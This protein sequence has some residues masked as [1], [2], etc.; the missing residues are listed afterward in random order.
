MLAAL[1]GPYSTTP[2]LDPNRVAFLGESLGTI[3][4]TDL[5]AI[6]PSIG[7]YVLDVPGGGIV[8]YVFPN[9]P[10]IADLGGSLA[11]IVW[12]AQGSLDKF[13]PLVGALQSLLD[14]ADSLT[15]ARHVLKDRFMVENNYLGRRHVVCIE[16][17]DDERMAN[18]A[19]EALARGFG[20]HVLR[21]NLV[22][23]EG[24][25]QIE[26]PAAGNVN[27]QTAVLVQYSPATHGYNWSAQHGDREYKPGG[28]QEGEERFTKLAHKITINEPIYET[29]DQVSEILSTY[30][31]QQPPRVRSTHTPVADFDD[32]G[33]PDATDPDPFDPTK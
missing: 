18:V 30:F 13:N 7:L 19:T 14:G 24:M 26:S 25:L 1:A 4:G 6:E 9:S 17:M 8:D 12:G 10:Y 33:K 27:S 23:P 21:P 2:K 32:D 3:V 29:L 31:G 15:F 5:A 11:E 22:A 16:A 20:M 28:P